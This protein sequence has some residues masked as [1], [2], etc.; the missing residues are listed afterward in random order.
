MGEGGSVSCAD[1]HAR[2]RSS[3]SL[4]RRL[5][6]VIGIQDGFGG[7]DLLL[8]NCPSC[9]SSLAIEVPA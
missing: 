5:L 8:G 1:R 2:A 6:K 9:Q 4:F 3:M 7:P